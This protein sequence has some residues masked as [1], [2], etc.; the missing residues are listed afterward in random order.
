M[1]L[2]HLKQPVAH[3]GRYQL[4]MIIIND[5]RLGCSLMECF[6]ILAVARV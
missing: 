1:I 6:F 4:A 5:K 2:K 3:S